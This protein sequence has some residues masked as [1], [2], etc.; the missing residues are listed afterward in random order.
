VLLL[1][2]SFH[3]HLIHGPD[4]DLTVDRDRTVQLTR[5]DGTRLPNPPSGQKVPPDPD[6]PPPFAHPRLAERRH[7]LTELAAHA[8]ARELQRD[9]STPI[10]DL[11]VRRLATAADE[12]QIA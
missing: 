10:L 3:H 12:R 7:T 11:T 4:I 1:L 9:I 5:R 8:L 2:C 6:L